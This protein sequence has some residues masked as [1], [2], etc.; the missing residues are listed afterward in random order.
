MGVSGCGKTIIGQMLSKQLGLP[1]FDG[2]R[3]HP[4]SNVNKMR[5]GIPLND[6]DREPWLQTLSNHI[7][8]QEERG[9]SIL[10]CSALKRSYRDILDK[11]KE[12]K[13]IFVHLKGSAELISRRMSKRNGH[14]MPLKLLTTQFEA[15][16]EPRG[17][18]TISI[19]Q[20]PQSVVE[21]I[22]SKIRVPK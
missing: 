10:A 14:F 7:F 17:G 6:H 22:V 19:D 18:I 12:T 4:A 11:K 2:D 8:E 15:L 16:E 9:G 21:E 3:F 13:V 5:S 1:F 20:S